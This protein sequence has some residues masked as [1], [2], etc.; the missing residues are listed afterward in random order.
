VHTQTSSDEESEAEVGEEEGESDCKRC[1][2][3]KAPVPKWED[4]KTLGGA[5]GHK[6]SGVDKALLLCIRI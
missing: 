6:Q 3:T 2:R 1:D 5:F 4:W